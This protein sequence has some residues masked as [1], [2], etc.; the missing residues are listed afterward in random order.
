MEATEDVTEERTDEQ[1]ERTADAQKAP[2]NEPIS[3]TT[4]VLIRAAVLLAAGHAYRG[5]D[6]RGRTGYFTIFQNPDAQHSIDEILADLKDNAYLCDPFELIRH[7]SRL[8][9][10]LFVNLKATHGNDQKKE[11]DRK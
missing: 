8:R 2:V 1:T 6:F 9:H 10:D 5:M 7:H 3:H 11:S 4:S